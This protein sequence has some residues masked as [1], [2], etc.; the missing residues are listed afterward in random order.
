MGYYHNRELGVWQKTE[1]DIIPFKGPGE[2]KLSDARLLEAI[3][4]SKDLSTSSAELCEYIRD[5]PSEYHLSPLRHN[6][7]RGFEFPPEFG[8]LELGSGCGAITRQLG[9]KGAVVHAVESDLERAQITA[10][11]CR[12]LP[13]VKVFLD[14]IRDF[15]TE[16]K[17]NAAVLIGV[18]EYATR[19]LKGADAAHN[20]LRGIYDLLDDNGTL[21]IGIENKLGIK[22]YNGH[23]E[24]HLNKE[25]WGTQGLYSGD[26]PCTWGKKEITELIINAGYQNIEFYY[27]FPDYKLPKVIISDRALNVED[28]SPADLILKSFSKSYLSSPSI[29]FDESLSLTELRKNNLFADFSNSFLI[30]AHKGKKAPEYH[31]NWIAKTFSQINDH[32]SPLTTTFSLVASTVMVEKEIIEKHS[33]DPSRAKKEVETTN[34]EKH[35]FTPSSREYIPGKSYLAELRRLIAREQTYEKISQYFKPWYDYL[36]NNVENPTKII[37]LTNASLCKDF[38]NIIPENFVYLDDNS[39]E[40]FSYNWSSNTEVPFIWVLIRGLARSIYNCPLKGSFS[41]ITCREF[42]TN[43]LSYYN[44][45]LNESH[46][47]KACRLENDFISNQ[48]LTDYSSAN[49]TNDFYAFLN[50]RLDDTN[51]THKNKL[52]DYMDSNDKLIYSVENL[53]RKLREEKKKIDKLKTIL[54]NKSNKI[55]EKNADLEKKEKEISTLYKS[56]SKLKEISESDSQLDSKPKEAKNKY[57]KWLPGKRS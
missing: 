30:F 52:A 31:D 16:K 33:D 3:K 34:F 39:I 57:L 15:S 19:F 5:W 41:N 45:N 24:D 17:F 51:Q 18:F 25:F 4:G 21:I 35:I 54:E 36:V 46:F 9:E 47:I 53:E 20:C 56:M 7:L 42:I 44:L 38:I 2:K 50:S 48:S 29:N 49:I 11:R 32:S 40:C 26:D 28:F 55:E 1:A 6:L 12:D 43:I 14:S 27:P 8:I 13:N 37:D 23:L 10:A 22:Y